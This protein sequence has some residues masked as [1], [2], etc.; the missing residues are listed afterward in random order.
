MKI[1]HQAGHNTNWNVESLKTDHSGNG[2]IFSPVHCQKK[3]ME[4]VSE[5]IKTTS[6][7][8]PQFYV[9]D[10]QKTK[11]HTYEFFPEVILNGFST[12][13]FE[14]VAGKVAQLCLK[15]QIDNNYENII[16]PARYHSELIT[17]YIEKQRV[18]SIEPFL[19]EFERLDVDKDIFITLPV[20][21]S[22]I[23]D[24]EYRTQLLNW[25]T[26]YPEIQGVYL[27]NEIGEVTKQITQFENLI[28]HINF[29]KELQESGLKVIIG[30]CNV[31]S[32]LLSAIDPYAV[33]FGAYENTRNFSID[34]FLISDSDKRGPAPRVY[35]PKLLNWIR[36]DT[37]IE[38]KED[39][40]ELWE[41]IYTPTDYMDIIF[42]AGTR[43]HFNKPELYKHHFKLIS[44]Q[45]NK[46]GSLDIVDRIA[47]TKKMVKEAS[48]LYHEIKDGGII[49][50]DSNCDG[51]HLPAW[52][53]VLQK[54]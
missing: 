1:Y 29:I 9:P 32:I 8:D 19:S 2:I 38:I 22:M 18:F 48:Q 43:P 5:D 34:K 51:E 12:T 21:R 10:S 20:T 53:R 52:N 15:F 35:M 26:S 28:F 25:I 16:I 23:Q 40:P 44:D 14:I 31:E 47:E 45:L 33:T 3:G 4:A 27:L 11:L 24:R 50:F 17:D 6:I 49:F 37:V 41:K 39:H 42:S 7:F 54:I 46:L 30:Y 13:D 36:Y